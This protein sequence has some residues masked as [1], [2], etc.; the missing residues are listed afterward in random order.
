MAAPL[1]CGEAT[2][3]AEPLH[4][5]IRM[6]R[7]PAPQV[8][9]EPSGGQTISC[10]VALIAN[11]TGSGSATWED[12]TARFS[13]GNEQ[14]LPGDS[15]VVPPDHAR[16]I[17]GGEWISPGTPR[18]SD[19]V[20]SANV[21]FSATIAFHYRPNVGAMRTASVTFDCGLSL[22]TSSELRAR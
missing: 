3:P 17:W 5:A 11:A 1:A 15:I 2:A 22:V 7:A 16:Q 20:L 13:F 8:T 21:P 18:T 14:A 4:V 12:A 6:D 9:N 10:E 19:I